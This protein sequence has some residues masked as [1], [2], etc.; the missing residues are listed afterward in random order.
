MVKRKA[1]PAQLRALAR[2]RAKLKASRKRTSPKKARKTVKKKARRRNPVDRALMR[3]GIL[4]SDLKAGTTQAHRKTNPP[5]YVVK[6]AS[7]GKYF[8]GAG[9]VTGTK[10]A[11]Q[12]MTKAK[13]GELGR[14]LANAIKQPV[15]VIAV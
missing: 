12:Y 13:A 11:A 2:G 9:W 1:S 15:F 3:T 4:T 6:K 10:N 7:D 5:H 14:K 8:D